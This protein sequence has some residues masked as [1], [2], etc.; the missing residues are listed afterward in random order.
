MSFDSFFS[1]FK[2]N[3]LSCN[4]K[5]YIFPKKITIETLI[6]GRFIGS[7]TNGYSNSSKIDDW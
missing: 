7:F 5:I 4:I 6:I 1:L 2:L 3:G